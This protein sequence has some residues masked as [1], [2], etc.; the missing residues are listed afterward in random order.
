M[1]SII[2]ML[3]ESLLRQLAN[4]TSYSRGEDY[5]YNRAVR[6]IKRIG[7]TF[8]GQVGGSE[9]YEVSLTLTNDAPSFSCSCPYHF[10]GI[11][12]HAVA[13]GMAVLE[14][15]GPELYPTE[16]T[17]ASNAPAVDLNILWQQTTTD[18]KLVF[19]R[20]L[21]DK[22]PDLRV[23]LT[24]FIQPET[25][26]AKPAED[27]RLAIEKISTEVY[28]ALSGLRFDDDGLEMDE[29]DYYSE[30]SPDPVPLIES[31]LDA[32]ADK[33]AAALREGRLSDALTLCMGV[34]EGTHSVI[35]VAVDDYGVI[36]DYPTQT[37]AV[38]NKLLADAYRQLASRVLH[39]DT[40][41]AALD[42]LAARVRYF[43]ET[44][45]EHEELYFD[46]KAFEP[47]LLALV[48]DMPSARAVQQ[49]IE[50]HDWQQR[51][52]EYIQLHIADTLLD[53]ESWLNTA[54]QFADQDATIGLQ[55]LERQN[56]PGNLA[57]VLQ[58]LHRLNK[59]FP[60]QFDAFILANIDE[61][62]LTP[63]PNLT[64]YLTALQTRARRTGQL[65]DYL[66]LRTY[67]P[68]SQRRAFADSLLPETGW[69]MEH[70][71]F[72]AQVL[73]TENRMTDLF[74]WLKT[75]NWP[76][77]RSLPDLL[78]IAAQ[79]HPTECL[80]LVRDRAIAQLETGK[81]DRTHYAIIANWLAALYTIPS[82]KPEVRILSTQLITQFNTLRALKDELMM[83]GLG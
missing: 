10:D 72:Y 1:I 82:L 38:W 45:E 76:Q 54:N 65:P 50:R 30:E 60:G 81:R 32:Y 68:E 7:N 20:Q 63:G 48:T 64:L 80:T 44:D 77:T 41:G 33:T 17:P 47:L 83:K 11:C 29:E 39:P 43:D 6:R 13:F 8:G 58:T 3:S 23:Q 56:E 73:Q 28:E 15:F 12:K 19:L 75:L 36:D 62:K 5:F 51:G 70:P 40:I 21:L 14:Q 31:M 59:H 69:Y 79:S 16:A 78:T 55:L 35:E 37:W 49:A 57:L 34:Y 52:T 46:V 2:H 66:K 26:P 27:N 4:A 53:Y 22:Q 42:Q 61:A 24:Q 9:R 67:W 74:M 71:L 18:Q 25:K